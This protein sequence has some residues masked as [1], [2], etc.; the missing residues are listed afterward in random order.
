V[1]CE[2]RYWD[3]PT[4][5]APDPAEPGL[6]DSQPLYLHIADGDRVDPFGE[7]I[8]TPDPNGWPGYEEQLAA[9]RYVTGSRHAVTTGLGN[10]SGDCSGPACRRAAHRGRV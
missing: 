9:A 10:G 3:Q 7:R 8:E 1:R 6:S 2:R 4:L 5:M